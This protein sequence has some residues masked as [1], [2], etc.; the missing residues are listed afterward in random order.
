MC[1]LCQWPAFIV[2]IKYKCLCTFLLISSVFH[3][4]FSSSYISIEF[5][6]LVSLSLLNIL[7]FYNIHIYRYI[8]FF[9]CFYLIKNE[10]GEHGEDRNIHNTYT[11][12][13]FHTNCMKYICIFCVYCLSFSYGRA[14]ERE[15]FQEKKVRCYEVI[16]GLW[17]S[18]NS[19]NWIQFFEGGEK[20]TQTQY[21]ANTSLN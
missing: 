19:F 9:F 8:F 2:Y 15:F 18:M 16:F 1:I 6:T 10:C 11:R 20:K 14:K 13:K 7:L 3:Y 4:I 12:R 21:R 17:N 5:I